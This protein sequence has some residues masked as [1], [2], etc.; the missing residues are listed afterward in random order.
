LAKGIT[1]SILLFQ[2]ISFLL[3]HHLY[4][5]ETKQIPCH[6]A[7]VK[8]H[9]SYSTITLF[10]TA[11]LSEVCA[12]DGSTRLITLL[13]FLTAATLDRKGHCCRLAFVTKSFVFWLSSFFLGHFAAQLLS[14]RALLSRDVKKYQPFSREGS[15]KGG[16]W[17]DGDARRVD[18]L[19]KHILPPKER[20]SFLSKYF[21]ISNQPNVPT[22][23]DENFHEEGVTKA[24]LGMLQNKLDIITLEPFNL[25]EIPYPCKKI[26]LKKD[27]LCP[28]K[29]LTD[30]A[31]HG[32]PR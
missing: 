6:D 23:Q 12:R 20:T 11:I 28:H 4:L 29:T 14:R 13:L 9:I 16:V 31:H 15:G 17:S 18:F 22:G 2:Q 26:A 7:Y 32:Y 25:H 8:K 21:T 19:H 27:E 3:L 30:K 10:P 24:S 5:I 1:V